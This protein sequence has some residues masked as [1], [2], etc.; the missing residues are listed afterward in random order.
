MNSHRRSVSIAVLLVLILWKG[1][2]NEAAE[3]G[4]VQ[5]TAESVADMHEEAG[6]AIEEQM[7]KMKKKEASMFSCSTFTQ[8]EVESLLGNP[9]DSGS[10]AFEHRR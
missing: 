1:G 5:E 3:Q 9:L 7:T 6:R 8:Q 10:Y 4:I 2:G